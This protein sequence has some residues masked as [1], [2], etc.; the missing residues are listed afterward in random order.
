MSADFDAAMLARLR[1][2]RTEASRIVLDLHQSG[3]KL[4]DAILDAI[5]SLPH[6]KTMQLRR[7]VDNW[8]SWLEW[9]TLQ[10]KG[11][12]MQI[13]PGGITIY[14]PPGLKLPQW[15]WIR[16]NNDVVAAGADVNAVKKASTPGLGDPKGINLFYVVRGTDAAKRITGSR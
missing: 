4:S 7:W 15:E 8:E 3:R 16:P 13:D 12:S 6:N 5:E 11:W 10:E 2:S 1:A 9:M 14:G